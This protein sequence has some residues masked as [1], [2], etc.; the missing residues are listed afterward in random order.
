MSPMYCAAYGGSAISCSSPAVDRFT[1]VV[2]S[3]LSFP[4][5]AACIME[6]DE[7]F[8]DQMDLLQKMRRREAMAERRVK[9]IKFVIGANKPDKVKSGLKGMRHEVVDKA[10]EQDEEEKDM[11][12][13][14]GFSKFGHQKPVA[15][16][17]VASSSA[18][19]TSPSAKP[20]PR[21]FDLQQLVQESVQIARKTCGTAAIDDGKD[22]DDSA[23][24]PAT[25][26]RSDSEEEDFVGPPLP[27]GFSG[28]QTEQSENR[29]AADSDF[30]DSD[31]DEETGVRYSRLPI[32]NDIS[33]QHGSKNISALAGESLS[34]FNPV[35][36]THRSVSRETV[37][38]NGARCVSGS[39][40]YE[41]RFWDFERM[42]HNLNSF[43]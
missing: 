13:I 12:V 3:L 30:S 7:V 41:I 10:V 9:G 22:D 32:T 17:S 16:T 29:I 19:T 21:S 23:D 33:L 39:Y 34:P 37:D 28:S 31:G 43:R 20:K 24:Q 8:E 35:I 1:V 18:A 15:E 25:T 5:P 11:C 42:D 14:M 38:T 36:S 2:S 27:P 4:S 26:E 6:G 40:D